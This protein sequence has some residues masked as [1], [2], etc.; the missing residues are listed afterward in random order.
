MTRV[1]IAI[2][3]IA[4]GLVS[5]AA[6][7][8]PID[9]DRSYER[10]QN[11]ASEPERST[12]IE[13]TPK[14]HYSTIATTAVTGGQTTADARRR[15]VQPDEALAMPMEIT[16]QQIAE[17]AEAH[18]RRRQQTHQAAS[19]QA[20]AHPHSGTWR[21]HGVPQ[22]LARRAA[23]QFIANPWWARTH[24]RATRSAPL[25]RESLRRPYCRVTSHRRAP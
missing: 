13:H 10:A 17:W 12:A 25:R 5:L 2:G 14:I 18:E 15:R 16:D 23:G 20:A 3:L 22:H 4:A 1:P 8:K 21:L 19:R 6:E 7:Q 9:L 24:S 11:I